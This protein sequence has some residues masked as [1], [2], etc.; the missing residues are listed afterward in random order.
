MPPYEFRVP[1]WFHIV[2]LVPT[3]GLTVLLFDLVFLPDTDLLSLELEE[4]DTM[5]KVIFG[6]FTFVGL[7]L[8]GVCT[9]RFVKNPVVFRMDDEGFEYSPGGVSTG[10]V[11]WVDVE[12][13]DYT[14]VKVGRPGGTQYLRVLGIYLKDPASFINRYPLAMHALFEQRRYDSGTPLV[15]GAGEFGRQHERVVAEMRERHARANA[16]R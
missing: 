6:F 13:L 3:I 4:I 14:R 2:C 5:A 1:R 16:G 9:Y 11:R 8:C 15:F 12:R 7:F 10:I